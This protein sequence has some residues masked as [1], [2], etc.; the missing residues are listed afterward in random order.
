MV[1][2]SYLSHNDISSDNDGTILHSSSIV[3]MFV[4]T[5]PRGV[6]SLQHQVELTLY[7]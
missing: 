6:S 3:K 4:E 7:S 2:S 5:G 1:S